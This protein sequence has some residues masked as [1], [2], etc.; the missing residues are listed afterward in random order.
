M[1]LS[2]LLALIGYAYQ[3]TSL[4]E[5]R[6]FIPMALHSAI[7]FLALALG[8]L[9]ARP[10]LGLMKV[11]TGDT[12]AGLL[13]R[14]LIPAAAAAPAILGWL[15]LLAQRA[16]LFPPELGNA[17]VVLGNVV[18]LIAL[19][20][21]NLSLLQ[22]SDAQRSI[23]ETALRDSER[24]FRAV[25]EQTAEGIYLIDADTR[26]V[27][28][29]N[30][31]FR[32]LLGYSAEEMA[33]RSVVDFIVDDPGVVEARLQKAFAGATCLFGERRYRRKDGS[34]VDVEVSAT[35]IDLG[36][37]RI[38]CAVARDITE[39]KRAEHLLHDKNRLLEEA[40]RSEREAR[41]ALMRAQGQMR[42]TEKFAA[43][44]Q[45]VAGV[46]HEINNPLSFVGN[47]VAVL[48]RDLRALVELL[49]LYQQSHPLLQSQQPEL[50]Q[51]V[52]QLSEQAELGYMLPN[53]HEMLARSR[54]GL[55]RIQQ[56]VRDLRDFAHLGESD[57]QEADLNAGVQSTMNIIVGHARKKQVRLATELGTL[58]RVPCYPAKINQVIL[59]LVANAIDA[60]PEGGTVTVRTA[61]E[62]GHARIEVIDRGP[63]IEAQVL[64]K[65]FDPF[66]TTKPPGE[67]TGL[68]LSISYGIV[69]DHGGAIDVDSK[70]G[71]GSRFV[72]SLPLQ[73]KRE[74]QGDSPPG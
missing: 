38:L 42:Q 60:S 52:R 67:G 44:G 16:Q 2:S 51:R 17:L 56:I 11:L 25:V 64:D 74:A 23:I 54:D 35:V 40:A 28:E 33:G 46:A 8:I 34:L 19:L 63:G 50:M 14:R 15:R 45:M 71:G 49:D 47:N 70:L 18:V 58:P 68:G 61:A 13:A 73:R 24:R 59:N 36:G 3:L 65:I 20:W 55:K 32:S 12:P 39:R 41:Q 26:Q 22:R 1:A 5:V 69:Q 37:R 7:C 66:F 6:S 21:W 29:T 53:L 27:L 30:R 57:L 4:Y 62:N 31:A 72:V 9:F 43:L 48:Q 10:D